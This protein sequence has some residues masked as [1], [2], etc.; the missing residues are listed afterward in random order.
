MQAI[1]TIALIGH[2]EHEKFVE[3]NE[4]QIDLLVWVG[5]LK[6]LG[7]SFRGPTPQNFFP[8]SKNF[9]F[10]KIERPKTFSKQGKLGSLS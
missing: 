1:Y 7:P 6:K 4:L 9:L 5:K 8:E 2:D 3:K 10:A